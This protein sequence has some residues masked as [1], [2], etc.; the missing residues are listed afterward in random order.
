MCH[1][2]TRIRVLWARKASEAAAVWELLKQ[3]QASQ[4]GMSISVAVSLLSIFT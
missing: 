4:T 3:Q 2:K 1:K